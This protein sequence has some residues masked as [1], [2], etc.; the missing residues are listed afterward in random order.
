[1]TKQ[2]LFSADE[3]AWIVEEAER[4]ARWTPQEFRYR[5]RADMSLTNRGD[6]AAAAAARIFRGDER[7]D[8]AAAARIFRGDGSRR[9]RG[10]RADIPRRRA[11]RRR[12]DSVETGARLRYARDVVQQ[13]EDLAEVRPWLEEACRDQIFPLLQAT[14]PEVVGEGAAARDALRIFDAKILR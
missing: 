1:M 8:A 13:V 10:R 5:R 4:A 14:F 6:A 2:P 12:D 9:R 11:R 7:G 3:C